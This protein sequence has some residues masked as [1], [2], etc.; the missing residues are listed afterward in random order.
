[1]SRI[2]VNSSTAA[3][4]FPSPSTVQG[5]TLGNGTATATLGNTN[6][7]LWSDQSTDAI[8][9][10][11]QVIFRVNRGETVVTYV[12]RLFRPTNLK[13]CK[14]AGTGVPVGTVFNFT[15]SIDTEGGLVPGQTNEPIAVSS[16]N[17]PAG[18]PAISSQGNCVRVSGPYE[19]A[20]PGEIPAFG[21]F[22]V[23]STITVTEA[24]TTPATTVT[25][26]SPTATGTNFTQVGRAGVLTFQHIGGFNEI[27]FVNSSGAPVSTGFSLSGRVMTP[28][29]GGLRNAQVILTK[30]DGT[31]MTVPTSSMGYYTFDGL[32]NETYTVGVS[33]R[34]YRF[35][36]RNVD[37]SSSLANVDFTG[38]E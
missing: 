29:G 38:I 31:K 5:V 36:A 3:S 32:A 33:S 34:R 14:V 9:N 22:D 19:S 8:N 11:R 6:P 7:N 30:A 12:N 2:S 24:V 4:N 17:I 35:N 26:T 21:T 10:R 25:A 23:G 13:I 20:N 16:V 27:I 1:V 28:D 15:F 37:L 18:D